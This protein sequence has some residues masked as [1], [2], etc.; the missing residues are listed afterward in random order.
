MASILTAWGKFYAGGIFNYIE[1]NHSPRSAIGRNEKRGRSS[2]TKR[3]LNERDGQLDAKQ[4]ITR[5]QSI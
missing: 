3:M 2:I 1:V 5:Q 4:Y